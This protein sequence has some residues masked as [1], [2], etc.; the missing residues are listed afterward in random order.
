MSRDLYNLHLRKLI[1]YIAL[2]TAAFHP[3]GN[4]FVAGATDGHIKIYDVKSGTSAAEFETAGIVRSV[5]FSEN[6]IW[7]ASASRGQT[8]VA[9]WDLRKQQQIKLLETGAPVQ[10]VVW[11]YTG[12]YLAASGPSGVTVFQYS[13][14]SKDWSEPLKAAVPCVAAQ[15]GQRAESL[16]VLGVDGSI[17][18]LA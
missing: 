16:M 14:S 3:D 15:W 7:L 4:L 12:Q 11:D 1:R 18:Q 17:S 6:G 10:N 2:T 13:K 9:I 8:S 5:A